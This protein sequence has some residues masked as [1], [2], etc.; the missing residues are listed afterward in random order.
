M[1]LVDSCGWLEYFAGGP[2]ADFFAAPLEDLSALL[3][4]FICI[5]EVAKRIMAQRGEGPA[6]QA[7][8]AMQQ[9]QVAALDESLALE[10][11]R[12]GL[13]HRLPLAD[14][15]ILATARAHKAII[16][17][18]DKDFE[19]MEGVRYIKRPAKD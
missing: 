1:N 7:A 3:V 16:W 13:E 8:A 5:L 15:V 4:P 11:A 2:N 14:S 10:A 19:G 18:Q 6:L 9:G 17:T 12:L